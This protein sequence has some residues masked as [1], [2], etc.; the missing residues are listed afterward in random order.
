MKLVKINSDERLLRDINS[1]AVLYDNAP[2][3]ERAKA[4]KARWKQEQQELEDLKNDVQQIK[5]LLNQIVEK[6]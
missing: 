2:E 4:R 5:N 3:I 1:N 6:L